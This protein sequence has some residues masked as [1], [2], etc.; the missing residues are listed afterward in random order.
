MELN[1][2]STSSKLYRWFYDK[3][4]MPETLCPYFWSLVFAWTLT[5][6]LSPLL[7][8]TWVAKKIS[9]DFDEDVP[10]GP[11]ALMGFLMY[12]IIYF[13]ISFGVF[14]SAYWITYYEGSLGFN[15]YGSGA[16]I[17]VVAGV[18]LIIWG[19]ITLKNR[20]RDRRTKRTI[21]DEELWEYVPNPDYVEPRPN[22]LVEFV[23]AKYNKYCP[24][25]DWKN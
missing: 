24:K 16:I 14:I 6:I 12:G 5:V 10:I 13:L 15:L 9:K 19:I 20:I 8:P 23:R 17:T 11:Y 25:I 22:L 2:N 4:D 3:R 7:L 18:A 1:Y 21:W